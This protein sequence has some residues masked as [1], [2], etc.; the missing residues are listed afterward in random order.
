MLKMRKFSLFVVLILLFTA[1]GPFNKVLNKGTS[2]EKYKMANDLY[3]AN[4][5]SKALQLF[6]QIIPVY[7]G[8]PQLE[9]IQFMTAQCFF[10]TK[11]YL[12]ASYYFDRFSA[13]YPKSTKKEEAEFFAA[14]SYF[15]QSPKYSV[16]QTDTNK[17][18]ESFQKFINAYPDSDKLAESNKMVKELQHKLEKKSFEIAKQ[19]YIIGQY[20]AAITSF[21]ILMSEYL[22]TSFREEALYYKL[23]AAHDLAVNSTFH[24]KSARLLA[25]EKAYE[26][27]KR[28]FPDSKYLKDSDKLLEEIKKQQNS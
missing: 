27:L 1:C 28:N 4:K 16:D 17:A 14:K 7:S 3:D 15:M 25:A 23:K 21:D 9:R 12:N 8:K 18:L 20:E 11:D 6:E 19:Y 22:G 26:K 24:K 10:N 5:F 13:N 2:E